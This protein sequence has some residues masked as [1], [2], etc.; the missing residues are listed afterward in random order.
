LWSGSFI[1][2]A[3]TSRSVTS[4]ARAAVRDPG[5]I[6][7]GMSRVTPGTALAAFLA[8]AGTS[9]FVVPRFFDG[10]VPGWLPGRARTWT[11]V[12]GAAEIGTAAAV[13]APRTRRL[14]GLIAAALFVAVY[15]ANVQMAVDWRDRPLWQRALAYGRLP[16]QAPLVGWAL[17]VRRE[18]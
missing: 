2:I 13:A 14:G 9:H 5:E 16:L 11:Y 15:P 12:S 7:Y 18:G 8:L 17:R 3:G 6:V 4:L 10:V 1:R